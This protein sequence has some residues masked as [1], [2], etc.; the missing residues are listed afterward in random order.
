MRRIILSTSATGGKHQLLHFLLILFLFL[1][2]EHGS[3]HVVPDGGAHPE[4]TLFVFIMMQVMV[5]PER[6]H[7]F[8]WRVPGVNG[9]MHGAVHQITEYKTREEHENIPVHYQVHQCKYDGCH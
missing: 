2:I 7:P 1:K 9:V 3:E 6:L 4:A 5:A 8:K